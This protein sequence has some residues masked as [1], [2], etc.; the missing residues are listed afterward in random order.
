M[1]NEQGNRVFKNIYLIAQFNI[2]TK[3]QQKN[4]I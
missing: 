3:H 2:V 1:N 4:N